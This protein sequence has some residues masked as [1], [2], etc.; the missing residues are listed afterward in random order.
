MRHTCQTAHDRLKDTPIFDLNS[1]RNLATIGDDEI[2]FS[3]SSSSWNNPLLGFMDPFYSEGDTRGNPIA[4]SEPS[5]SDEDVPPLDLDPSLF[6]PIDI[7]PI[8]YTSTC[9]KPQGNFNIR[10]SRARRLY[11]RN[12]RKYNTCK[13]YDHRRKANWDKKQ[14]IEVRLKIRAEEERREK[15]IE[16]AE[17]KRD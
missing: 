8:P 16:E 3:G 11:N 7:K 5:S 4:A 1:L 14:V 12:T 6:E 17:K 10:D 15:I 2:F 13:R 9:Q